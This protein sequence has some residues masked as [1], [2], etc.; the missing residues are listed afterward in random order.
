MIL[1]CGELACGRRAHG[2][3]FKR[4][5]DNIKQH[6]QEGG[7][8][9]GNQLAMDRVGWLKLINQSTIAVKCAQQTRDRKARRI[10]AG[11]AAPAADFMCS[12]CS[13]P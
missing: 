6:L 9:V 11:A 10:A 3:Q 4:F 7:T 2:G 12:V 1:F 8:D 5:K 13:K